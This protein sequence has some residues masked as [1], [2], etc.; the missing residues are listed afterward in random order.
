MRWSLDRRAVP[1][2]I[3]VSLLFPG[4]AAGAQKPVEAAPPLAP[5]WSVALDG[6][7]V[8]QRVAPL[9]QLL[10]KTS[11]GLSGLDPERGRILW[12]HADL[13]GLSDDHYEEIQG[14]TLVVVSDG[15]AQPR[16]VVLDSVDGRIL[17]DSRRA[18]VSQV[19]SRHALPQSRALLLFGFRE[20]DPATTM[21]L[22]DVDSG[23]LRWKNTQLLGGQGKMTQALAAFF[24]KATNQ[25]GIVG[26]PMEIDADTF[27]VASTT[28][29]YSVRIRTGE[30]AWRIPNVRD[31]RNTRFFVTERAPGVVFI[32][33]ETPFGMTMTTGS[34]GTDA[35]NT[36]Y[37]AR[38]LSDGAALWP[39]QAIV[40]G[41]LND[42]V[43][44]DEG[45]ILS[46]RTTGK[47]KVLLCDYATGE[48]RWGKK[49]KGIEILGGIINHDWTSAGLVLTTGYDSAWT[50]KG[51]RYH[52]T[53]LDVKNGSLRFA[54]PLPLRGR[55]RE[56]Q[57]IP[58]G[59]LFTTTS[60]MNIL[61]LATGRALLG[62][63]VRS[64]ESLVAAAGGRQM[65]AYAG[66][67][68]TL[69]RLDLDH[70]TL[71]TVSR[72]PVKLEEEDVPLA[73]EVDADR[74]TL[75]SSQNVVAWSAS[76]DLLFHAYHASPRLPAL[77]RILLRA[78]QVRM[79][80]AAAAAGMAS[81]TLA[82]AST[83]TQP[84]SLQ[85]QV[86]A[87]AATG[88]ARAGQQLAA[89]SGRYGEI[90][91]TRFKATTTAPEFVFM[92]VERERGAH[93]LAKVNKASGRVEAVIDLG[94]DKEPVYDVDAVA[95]MIFY[96]STQNT[97]AAY[98][99]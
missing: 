67:Q 98:R 83:G 79:G 11:R 64:D 97:V 24:Q 96:R 44:T 66:R 70:G 89:A 8:W 13:G 27:L 88:Y 26:G 50:D 74:V 14:T 33:S 45:L 41:G 47:G 39:K 49:G 63:G 69:H 19:L 94:R 28:E 2:L 58:A 38:R 87:T 81:A 9:G 15:L 5:A 91:R 10:V 93:G 20:G 25:S 4:S 31:A 46:P 95:N 52:L 78:E 55:I 48:S 84:A 36:E 65:Y 12:S 54:E 29:V 1:A 85:R 37:M 21:F 68:G 30:I 71:T 22:V 90:A 77:T 72:S 34:G 62:D 40:R 43:F 56:T 53:V 80:M 35:V 18:G 59:L 23:S 32:G 42:V 6:D 60:E 57:V 61:D 17:F 82:A 76:G 86:T 75:I 92:M 7:V 99:F 3:L 16:V 73:L 51:T